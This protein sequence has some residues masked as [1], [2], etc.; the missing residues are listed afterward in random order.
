MVTRQ[1]KTTPKKRAKR[2]PGDKRKAKREANIVAT[3]PKCPRCGET[4]WVHL[5]YTS[6]SGVRRYRCYSETCKANSVRP[7]LGRGFVVPK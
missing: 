4:E 3:G 6:S 5:E 7:G 2:R 1:K